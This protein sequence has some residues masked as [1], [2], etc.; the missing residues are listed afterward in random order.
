[1]KNFC[2]LKDREYEIIYF[3]D[4]ESSF[5]ELKEKSKYKKIILFNLHSIVIDAKFLSYMLKIFRY[6]IKNDL[7]IIYI[8]SNKE[9]LRNNN[10]MEYRRFFKIFSSIEEYNKLKVFSSFEVKIYDDN[11]HIKNILKD[12][13]LFN[14]FRLKE[15]N[16]LNFLKKEHDSRSTSIYI[17]DF[18]KYKE[19][20][21]EEIKKIKNKNIDSIIILTVFENDLDEALKIMKYGV[22]RVVKRPFDLKEFIDIIKSLAISNQLKKENEELIEKVFLREK[23]I[24]SLYSSLNE[25]LK[26]ASDIQKS[27]LPNN[28]II[29]NNYNIEYI[30]LPS[31]KIGGDFYEFIKLDDDRF[32]I[33]FADI[34]GH[35]ISAALLSSMLKV[36]LRNNAFKSNSISKILEKINEEIIEVFPKGK[37]ISMFYLVLDTF[38]NQISYAKASQESALM[39]DENL[40]DII[41]L[42]AKGQILGM[43]SKKIFP[44]LSFEEKVKEFNKNDKLVLY[45]DGIIEE[46]SETK[47]VYGLDRLKKFVKKANLEEIIDD[48]MK[49]SN[50]KQLNDDVT[51]LKIERI[52]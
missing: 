3:R 29:F 25:E 44:N 2:L 50:K 5:E 48:L 37:Y 18:E 51:I 1:M 36:S 19:E 40:D 28:K 46:V 15:R 14:G 23:E 10:V 9:N 41:E 42:K 17:V 8:T 13:L 21:I 12:E 45:T 16:S 43:F 11:L 4:L 34:S 39:Y 49:F 7:E 35:G 6:G 31:M 47:E 38:K 22:D 33:I 27:L 20:K 26:I 24:S 52:D 30:F 32:A